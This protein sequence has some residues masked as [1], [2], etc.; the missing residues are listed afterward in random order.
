MAVVRQITNLAG[1][2]AAVDDSEC[3]LIVVQEGSVIEIESRLSFTGSSLEK[4]IRFEPNA[5]VEFSHSGLLRWDGLIETDSVCLHV[6]RN[7]P[8]TESSRPLSGFLRNT[9]VKPEWFGATPSEHIENIQDCTT[10]LKLAFE[11]AKGL[12]TPD[13]EHTKYNAKGKIVQLNRGFYGVQE[14]LYVASGVELRGVG[15]VRTWLVDI[16]D[17]GISPTLLH[18]QTVDELENPALF[19]NCITIRDIGLRGVGDL[20]HENSWNT[21]RLIYGRQSVYAISI[22]NCRIERAEILVDLRECFGDVSLKNSHLYLSKTFNI[23]L[24]KCHGF[25]L[26]HCRVEVCKGGAAVGLSDGGQPVV[27]FNCFFQFNTGYAIWARGVNLLNLRD[28]Y[29]EDSYLWTGGK[30]PGQANVASHVIAKD[31]KQVNIT[32]CSFHQE[33]DNQV[34]LTNPPAMYCVRLLNTDLFYFQG[35]RITGKFVNTHLPENQAGTDNVRNTNWIN[36]APE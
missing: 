18:L 24:S 36:L 33:R 25:R 23:N 35:N 34:D 13:W 19:G 29:F 12:D 17:E 28:C 1:F 22:R 32:G 21:K 10:A 11:V 7:T 6:F 15:A 26:D 5:Y 31:C 4:T 30:P 20:N 3:K 14:T 16:S 27:F 8:S 9:I 2:V